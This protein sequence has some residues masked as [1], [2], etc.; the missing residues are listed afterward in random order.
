[1]LHSSYFPTLLPSCTNITQKVTVIFFS[2]FL[3]IGIK[4]GWELHSSSEGTQ[5]TRHPGGTPHAIPVR[6]RPV[7]GLA[8]QQTHSQT[9]RSKGTFPVHLPLPTVAALGGAPE[10]RGA[11]STLGNK[12]LRTP[13]SS[14]YFCSFHF[15]SHQKSP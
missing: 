3:S 15:L 14:F 9:L 7:K 13:S 2:S 4:A 1:M 8:P 6:Q 11:G 5:A 12:V 10:R